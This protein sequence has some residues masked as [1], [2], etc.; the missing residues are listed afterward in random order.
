VV[1][2]FR[3]LLFDRRLFRK[4]WHHS[5]QWQTPKRGYMVAASWAVT[6]RDWWKK[7]EEETAEFL[8]VEWKTKSEEYVRTGLFIGRLAIVWQTKDKSQQQLNQK[9]K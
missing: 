3:R 7:R 1:I 4:V 2:L 6:K 8:R 9:G 5:I